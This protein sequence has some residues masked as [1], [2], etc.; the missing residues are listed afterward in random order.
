V[1]SV[2]KKASK[3]TLEILFFAKMMFPYET[4]DV[5]L[6]KNQPTALSRLINIASDLPFVGDS[7]PER[8]VTTSCSIYDV[9][10][11]RSLNRTEYY[12]KMAQIPYIAKNNSF[13]VPFAEPS[14]T[15]LFEFASPQVARNVRPEAS[16]LLKTLDPNTML[17]HRYQNMAKSAIS[18]PVTAHSVGRFLATNKEDLFYTPRQDPPLP[19]SA[20]RDSVYSSN[21]GAEDFIKAKF[22]ARVAGT[23]ALAL[24]AKRLREIE[25]GGEYSNYAETELQELN[26]SGRPLRTGTRVRTV[27][28]EED[29]F[30]YGHGCAEQEKE[31]VDSRRARKATYKHATLNGNGSTVSS[32][33]EP[34]YIA[35]GANK[36]ARY[37]DSSGRD[38]RPTE[39]ESYKDKAFNVRRWKQEEDDLLMRVIQESES[40]GQAFNWHTICLR[41]S[42]RT[43]KQCRERWHSQLD[44]NICRAKWTN[45]EEKMLIQLHHDMGNK[46][47]EIAKLMPGRT[48]NSV[49]NQ[50]KSIKRRLE[51]NTT[52]SIKKRKSME[53]SHGGYYLKLAVAPVSAKAYADVHTDSAPNSARLSLDP[54]DEEEEIDLEDAAAMLRGFTQRSHSEDSNR[55]EE[56]DT[57]FLPYG[58]TAGRVS[59]PLP[60]KY[61][62]IQR[63][64]GYFGD[65]EAAEVHVGSPDG[66]SSSRKRPFKRGRPKASSARATTPNLLTN[67]LSTAP[68]VT[69]AKSASITSVVSSSELWHNIEN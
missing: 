7:T 56:S 63:E 19:Q 46:W 2:R 12:S 55:S 34:A 3:H 10:A 20:S 47:T 45:E 52:H 11:V 41:I 28:R 67:M 57:H 54:G 44:P 9:Y 8:R 38:I 62:E 30:E 22:D 35:G 5:S 59:P 14:Q 31:K 50:W 69:P 68:A 24:G 42:G 66:G 60:H 33:K 6:H 21:N 43:A 25:A 27:S 15:R 64:D 4:N 1:D 40:L 32:A 65:R 58:G 37:N 29:D 49:K 18:L 26:N 13:Y 61:P 48:D 51:S 17:A 16:S 53:R 23:G 39:R 36:A